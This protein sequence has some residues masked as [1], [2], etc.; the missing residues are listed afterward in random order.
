MPFSKNIPALLLRLALAASYLSAVADRFGVWGAPEMGEVTWGNF[1]NF[2]AY[3]AL[4]NPYVPSAA[5]PALAWIATI[6]EV[7]LAIGLILG[8]RLRIVAT[9]SAILLGIFAVS[10]SLTTGFEGP[11]TYSVWTAAGASLVLA[12]N[13]P[14]RSR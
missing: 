5:I 6:L 2:I 11:L 13:A 14:N 12:T 8:F 3:T 7:L 4:L 10:M 9:V 1:E